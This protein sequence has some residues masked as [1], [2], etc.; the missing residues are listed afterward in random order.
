MGKKFSNGTVYRILC[1][2]E[3]GYEPSDKEA[4]ILNSVEALDI[5]GKEI[6]SL[7]ETVERMVHLKRLDLSNNPILMLPD[8]LGGLQE[9]EE[10]KLD[11][12]Q[13]DTLPPCV[14]NLSNLRLLSLTYTPISVLPNAVGQLVNLRT[15]DLQASRVSALPVTIGRLSE[16]QKLD[17]RGTPIA[18]LPG[19]IRQLT[20]LQTLSLGGTPLSDLPEAVGQLAALRELDLAGTRITSLPESI[21]QLTE[22]QELNLRTNQITALPGSLG[23]LVKL[24]R[25]FL[26]GTQ[27]SALPDSIG[28]LA[29]LNTLVLD[30]AP[31]RTLPESMERL[32]QLQHLDLARTRISALPE[33]LGQLPTLQRLDLSGL[34]LPAIPESLALHGLPFV[35]EE[36]LPAD[37]PGVNLHGAS[38][39]NQDISIFLVHPELIPSLY[40]EEKITLR[41]SRVI[42]LGDGA[43]GKS[44]TIQ[45]ISNEGKQRDYETSETPGVMIWDFQAVRDGNSFTLHFWD[46]GGQE[47]LHSMHRFFLTDNACYVVMVKTRETNANDRARYWLRNV[48]A[49]A[50]NSPILLFVNCWEHDDGTRTIDEPGLRGEFPNLNRVI[51]C[52]AKGASEA[53]FRE[54]VMEPMIRMVEES[55]GVTKQ[56]PKAWDIVRRAIEKEGREKNYLTRERYHQLCAQNKIENDEAPEL[57]SFFN[58]LG[59]CFSYHMDRDSRQ[60]LADYRLLD[61]VWLTNGIYA[62]IREGSAFAQEGRIKKS[63]IE[64]LLC[65]PAPKT[66]GGRP[67]IRTAPE[68]TYKK[69]ECPYLLAVAEAYEL[70]YQ[71]NPET[72]FF[73]ALCGTDTPEEALKLPTDFP[74]RVEYRLQY[75]YL[76]DSVVHRLMIRCMRKNLSIIY[77]WRKGLVLGWNDT[78]RAVVRMEGADRR[79]S[80][81]V[82]S[83]AEQPAYDLFRLLREEMGKINQ[84]L[85]LSAREYIVDGEDFYSLPQLIAAIG[86]TDTVYGP[87][88]GTTH[89]ASRLL[90]QFYDEYATKLMRVE[91]GVIM[92]PILPMEYH[93]YDPQ[94]PELRSALYMA[95]RGICPYCSRMIETF[96]DMEVDHIFPRAYRDRVDLRDYV[97]YLQQKGFDPENPNYVENF[98]PAHRSCNRDKGNSVDPFVLLSRHEIAAKNAP[99]VLLYLQKYTPERINSFFSGSGD[100]IPSCDQYLSF[101]NRQPDTA[102]RNHVVE[103]CPW[104]FGWS[105]DRKTLVPMQR[106]EALQMLLYQ[107]YLIDFGFLDRFLRTETVNTAPPPSGKEPRPGKTNEEPP[108]SDDGKQDSSFAKSDDLEKA[109]QLVCEIFDNWLRK[110]KGYQI[111]KYA[112]PQIRGVQYGYDVGT[113]VRRERVKYRL[114]FECKYYTAYKEHTKDGTTQ[115]I[116]INA[117]SPNFLQYYMHCSRD[118]NNRWILVSPFGDVQNDF[119]EKLFEQWSEEHRY[120]QVFA[121]TESSA[122]RCREFFSLSPEAYRLVYPDELPPVITDSEREDILD[123]MSSFIGEDLVGLR[124]DKQL[125]ENYPFWK[126][127]RKH[128]FLL[129]VRT[130]N[131]ADAVSA[132]LHTILASSEALRK[133]EKTNANPKNGIYVVG[134]YGSGKSWTVY[135]VIEELVRHRDRYQTIPF[136]GGLGDLAIHAGMSPDDIDQT[137]DDFAEEIME[138]AE[139]NENLNASTLP[140]FVLDGFDEVLSGLSATDT[141]I[142]VLQR[143]VAAIRSR[144]PTAF[145][146]VTSRE[147]DYQ[148]CEKHEKFNEISQGYQI[149][150]LDREGCT[151]GDVEAG[152]ARLAELHT[153]CNSQL[154]YLTENKNLLRIMR[155]P[156][157]FGLV[158]NYILKDY[159]SG[160]FRNDEE[161]DEHAV[162]KKIVDRIVETEHISADQRNYWNRL[163]IKL[164]ITKQTHAPYSREDFGGNAPQ[165]LMRI[166]SDKAGC[167]FVSFQ[168]NIIREYFVG[169]QLYSLLKNSPTGAEGEK[170]FLT[171]LDAVPLTPEI[172]RSF[173]DFIQNGRQD[174][175][176]SNQLKMYLC[177]SDVKENASLSTKLLEIL[178]QPGCELSG[179]DNYWLDLSGIHAENLFLRK[180]SLQYLNLRNANL[181]KLR[182]IDVKL[183]QLDLS[184]A[185]LTGL[186]VFSDYPVCSAT[187]WRENET[188]HL[189]AINTKGQLIKYTFDSLLSLEHYYAEITS[190]DTLTQYLDSL[191]TGQIFSFKNNPVLYYDKAIIRTNPEQWLYR[192]QRD[193]AIV[194]IIPFSKNDKPGLSVFFRS[195]GSEAVVSSWGREL[196]VY[197]FQ[198]TPNPLISVVDKDCIVFA[199]DV[200]LFVINGG[201]NQEI[202]DCEGPIECLCARRTGIDSIEIDVKC[203]DMIEIVRYGAEIEIEKL[204]PENPE[205]CTT[206]YKSLQIINANT[207]VAIDS[208]HLYLV[209]L[210]QGRYRITKLKTSVECDNLILEDRAINLRLQDDNAYD[211]LCSML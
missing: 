199:E 205:V 155:R 22:L 7:P 9:L 169:E 80:I 99:K 126:N 154:R 125:K 111:D 28:S 209:Q 12:T 178:L 61:P 141:K 133:P 118:V 14:C 40:Q 60:E 38:L 172:Q 64:Q 146:I 110:T 16:L 51:Y 151:E 135:Q 53:E 105:D 48:L 49:F 35:D 197:P 89:R 57:L 11:N 29:R 65:N 103:S 93:Y 39:T 36:F 142:Q 71:V 43:S 47:L 32:A 150:L 50:P 156:F 117:Y 122:V 129:P 81:A 176:D 161:L 24:Q 37:K 123:R 26:S 121:I 124:A 23:Q 63:A 100:S 2:I 145:I 1:K 119:P 138:P 196:T 109:T 8:A 20:K 10:L 210:L 96:Q 59:V 143:I 30:G 77:C 175:A 203:P 128:E 4:E 13:L 82:L 152:I 153:D 193:N 170:T 137:A 191:Q 192:I 158:T 88:T 200:K 66:V 183:S 174:E 56:V 18:T 206:P 15:L 69:E 98:F 188:W 187:S 87:V 75:E 67:H 52:S 189:S 74:H 27:I 181:P 166:E 164:T 33:W 76:P 94:K 114:C 112:K 58:N 95:Y 185:N 21:G 17:L 148:A 83:R 108:K 127:Y 198:H 70:C 91:D 160:L 149:I 44:Y 182:L 195:G 130:E 211:L 177:R 102:I 72:L 5:S 190:E 41:E 201:V 97:A 113:N 73:P 139:D 159:T 55:E 45:R 194:R 101:L 85:N 34:S 132:I 167:R 19:M 207:L 68:K 79:L 90:G 104:L 134:E 131:G 84:A 162:L 180:C 107:I 3:D 106:D 86:S 171:E 6:T 31:I 165:Y 54:S 179:S 42:F 147:S 157:F 92:V 78:H 136:F 62:V 202:C 25:L 120:M 184:G 168:H 186:Q 204:L 116:K 144:Y 115:N 140:L 208:N 173:L 163:A 46:F